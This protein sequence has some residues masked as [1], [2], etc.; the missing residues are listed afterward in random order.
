MPT[1]SKERDARRWP[2]RLSNRRLGI[3]LMVAWMA[4]SACVA[5][6]ALATP[7]PASNPTDAAK[8]VEEEPPSVPNMIRFGPEQGLSKSINDLAIDRQ[9]FVW[10]ATADGLA[11][12][13]G[14]GFRH[15]R[16]DPKREDSLPSNSVLI[17]SVDAY[18]RIW[19]VANEKLSVL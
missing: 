11:R 18:D 15:W 17:I 12:Y 19:V 9:G 16:H 7:A 10:I 3:A 4:L 2:G 6:L 1:L 13:D 14:I 5:V 8:A